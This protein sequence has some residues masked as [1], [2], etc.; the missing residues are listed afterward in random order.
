MHRLRI[1]ALVVFPLIVGHLLFPLSLVYQVFRASTFALRDWLPMVYLAVGYVGLIHVSG[2]WSWFGRLPRWALP[3]LLAG[4]TAVRFVGPEPAGTRD[5]TGRTDAVLSL[6]LGTLLLAL[7][8]HAARGRHRPPGALD[9]AFPLRG[10]TFVVGQGGASKLVNHHFGHPS[11]RYAFDLLRLNRA[12]V[13]ARGIYPGTLDRYAAWDAEVVSPCDGRV[14][15]VVDE[16]PDLPPPQ[17][18]GAHPAGNHVTIESG[19]ATIYLAHLRRRSLAVRAGDMVRVGQTI[20]RVGN[21][22]NTTEPHLHIHAEIGPWP[23][24]FSGRP[25]VPITFGGRF[26]VRNDHVIA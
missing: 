11:Q 26:L 13:R 18:D 23:G 3:L 14:A 19:G 7:L 24:G 1:L 25:G 20:G 15:V 9:L 2:A 10:G 21:S 17:R 6:A 16:I 5:E 22:G 4:A 8:F 12:G